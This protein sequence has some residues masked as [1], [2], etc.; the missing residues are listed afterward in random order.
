MGPPSKHEGNVLLD[1]EMSRLTDRDQ[2]NSIVRGAYETA[3]RRA[4]RGGA[5]FVIG[6]IA[7]KVFLSERLFVSTAGLFIAVG[8]SLVCAQKFLMAWRASRMLKIPRSR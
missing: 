4:L 6:V 1:L 3:Q 7:M 5:G 2:V 8:S